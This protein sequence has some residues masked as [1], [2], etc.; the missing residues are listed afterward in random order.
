MVFMSTDLKKYLAKNTDYMVTKEPQIV[1]I[2]PSII[3]NQKSG[4]KPHFPRRFFFTCYPQKFRYIK[5]Y[6]RSL[7]PFFEEPLYPV[8]LFLPDK[9]VFDAS[10]LSSLT[11]CLLIFL[12]PPR[13]PR[14]ELLD[15]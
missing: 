4:A 6:L 13:V 11:L 9:Q 3:Q 8:C 1:Q 12:M 10:S 15:K 2:Q 7:P 5:D 14:R